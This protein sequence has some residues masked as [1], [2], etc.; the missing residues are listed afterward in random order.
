MISYVYSS[1]SRLILA[2][3]TW[4]CHRV[5]LFTIR[6]SHLTI[7]YC[8]IALQTHFQCCMANIAL[9]FALILPC[10]VLST[11]L[12]QV[13]LEEEINLQTQVTAFYGAHTISESNSVLN[14][15]QF[16][17]GVGSIPQCLVHLRC[18]SRPFRLIYSLLLTFI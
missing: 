16:F 1:V 6:F 15:A 17:R 9:I 4:I 10:K 11:A 18:L 12:K 14:T 7:L 13:Q 8:I 5:P 2:E 3:L